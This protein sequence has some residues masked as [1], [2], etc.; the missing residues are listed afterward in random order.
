MSRLEDYSVYK[1]TRK[2]SGDFYI[3]ITSRTVEKRWQE[4]VRHAKYGANKGHFYRAIRKYGNEAF[5]VNILFKESSKRAAIE[6]EILL[7]A[8]FAPRYN[9]TFGGDG[10]WGHS[11]SSEAREKMKSVHIGNKY[12]L[13]RKWS[14]E[15]KKLMSEKK[16]GCLP[17]PV[18]KKMAI[19]RAHNMRKAAF[20]R[21]LK[22]ICLN[23]CV[24]YES[25]TEAAL[26][27]SLSKSTVC[28][29]CLGKRSSAYGLKFKYIGGDH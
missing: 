12:N 23:D 6:A 13:G 14:D 5:E 4:H 10:S 17:P 9:S 16:K 8:D 3:G 20:A 27:Y 22:V 7:I 1:I 2:D 11:V 19:S 26:A 21:R 24:I 25:A 29:I 15:Q 18:S 28:N